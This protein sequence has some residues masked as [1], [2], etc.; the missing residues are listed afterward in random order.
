MHDTARSLSSFKVGPSSLGDRT[1]ERGLTM[2]FG[3][4]I[5]VSSW[6]L[7]LVQPMFAKMVLPRLGGTPAVWNTCVVFFQATLLIGYLY[8]YLTTRWLGVRRQALVHLGVLIVPLVAL[9]IGVAGEAPP[10]TGTPVWW[11]LS[12]LAVSVGLPFFVVS[13]TSPLL[14]RWF[15]VMPHRR[16]R[17]P[18]FLYSS[19]NFASMLALM[20]YPVVIEPSLRLAQ[21]SWFSGRH[22][23]SRSAFK[24]SSSRARWGRLGVVASAGWRSRSF[25]RV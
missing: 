13:T 23:R 17:D 20:S 4:A 19:S 5:L 6:L 3:A 1:L 2:L 25:P 24:A 18:Y 21:Q 11:L 15:S 12:V 14:Q 10:T 7:F 8:A 9:P 16:A 22:V